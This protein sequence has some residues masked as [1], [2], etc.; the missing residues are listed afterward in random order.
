MR[1]Y[2]LD[3]LNGPSSVAAVVLDPCI[4]QLNVAILVR[5]LVLL[6]P[7]GHSIGSLLRR[8]TMLAARAVF[9][10]QEPLI[11]ALQFFF[12]HHTADRFA[13]FGQAL[14]CL[15]VRA[16]DPGIVGQLTGLGDTDVERLSVAVCAGT[17]RPFEDVSPM[18]SERH[19][20]RPRTP[21]DVGN[22]LYESEIAEA[23]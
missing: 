9:C 3:V 17:S 7:T 18:T 10:L 2:D 8:F 20:R 11:L 22:G 21:D 23:F 13:P 15:H 16:V 5:E 6:S 14:G 4:R 19:Q 12:E 1:G